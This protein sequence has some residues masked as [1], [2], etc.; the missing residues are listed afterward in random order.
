MSATPV[1]R[2]TDERITAEQVGML[3]RMAPHALV[4]SA[5]G[6]CVVLALF[7]T[8]VAT[9]PLVVW[10]VAVNLTCLA[11][12]ALVRAYR[13]AAPA[14]EDARTWARY[15]MLAT[16]CAGAVWGLLGTPLL[17]VASQSYQVIFSVVNVA[18]SAIGI[19]ALYPW[20]SA[21]VALVLP[22]MLPSALTLLARGDGES[23]L[24]AVV[25]IVFVPLAVNAARRIGRNNAES[26]QLRFDIKAMSE[27]HERAKHAAEVAR[28]SAED[29]NRTKSEFLANMSHEIRTPMNGVLGMTELLLD[30]GLTEVQRRYAQTVRNSGESLLHIINDILDFSKIEAGKMELDAVE[31]DLRETTEEVVELLASRAYGK[32]LELSCHIDDQVPATVLGDAGRLRQVLINLVGNAVKFTERGEIGI[33]VTRAAHDKTCVPEGSC[34]LHF[35][36]RDTGI[37]ISTEARGRM[38][39]AFT[40]ADGSTSRRFGGTGLGL[41]ISKQLIE[42]MEGEIEMRSEPGRGSTFS[43][44]LTLIECVAAAPRGAAAADLAGLRALIVEDNP[45]NRLILERYVS[46]CGI[47]ADSVDC[48]ERALEALRDAAARH[49]P[50]DVALVDMKMPGMNGVELAQA[51]RGDSTLASTRLIMLA[52]LCS[53]EIGSVRDAGFAAWINKPVRRSELF[54]CIAGVMGT[55]AAQAMPRAPEIQVAPIAARVLLVEDNRV[56]QEVCKAILR[57]LGCEVDVA[58]DG[59]AGVDAAFGARYDLV[60]MDCQMPEMDGFD[61]SRAIRTREAELDAELHASGLPPRRLPIIALTANAMQGDR[62]RCLNAGMDDYLAKPFKKDQLAAMLEKWSRREAVVAAA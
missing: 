56:N 27:Q 59:R 32:G 30:T 48:G 3:Y 1:P 28:Q 12:Y 46:A 2:K 9:G 41:V 10:F 35:E 44:T 39:K 19:F 8:V 43:F 33:T 6:A 11:R 21:Y 20:P 37:G 13:R 42:L 53:S 54:Q 31:F 25:L 55:R 5:F 52:S 15:Y 29:A 7:V 40:Q 60:L 23:T 34:V 38:F 62:E 58:G 14:P 45:T 18:V 26:I 61:A 49:T 47:A 17:P 16:F 36:V 4:M 22:F 57:K 50:Y 24:L 51:V